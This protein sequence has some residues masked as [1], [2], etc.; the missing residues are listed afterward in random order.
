MK[1]RISLQVSHSEKSSMP[2]ICVCTADQ[3]IYSPCCLRNLL[4]FGFH[5]NRLSSSGLSL[6]TCQLIHDFLNHTRTWIFPELKIFLDLPELI[7]C[8]LLLNE[9]GSPQYRAWP[10]NFDDTT[11]LCLKTSHKYEMTF[12]AFLI[13]INQIKLFKYIISF[14]SKHF[15][16]VENQSIKNFKMIVLISC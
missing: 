6:E 4:E 7:V 3:V 15:L 10:F 11:Q 2:T 8:A 12:L 9:S 5:F 13:L 16:N 1:F 14:Q